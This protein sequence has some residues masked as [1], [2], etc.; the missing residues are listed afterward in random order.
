M[1]QKKMNKMIAGIQQ[2]VDT[3]IS[4]ELLFD[5]NNPKINAKFLY[6]TL[7][8]AWELGIKTIY[9]IRTIQKDSS[10]RTKQECESCA[11]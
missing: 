11:G 6:D 8:D 9:Y 1:D 2:W 5:L 3:G 4:Y 7:M 10:M